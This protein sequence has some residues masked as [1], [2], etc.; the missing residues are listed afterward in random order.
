MHHSAK[1]AE[2]C[3]VDIGCKRDDNLSDSLTVL[4]AFGLASISTT[5]LQKPT[6]GFRDSKENTYI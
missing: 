3:T 4:P 1:V 2:L 6:V 5:A